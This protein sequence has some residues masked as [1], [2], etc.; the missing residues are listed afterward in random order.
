[1]IEEPDR[2]PLFRIRVYCNNGLLTYSVRE[3]Y[4]VAFLID[5]CRTRIAHGYATN[6]IRVMK[7]GVDLATLKQS[8]VIADVDID[9]TTVLSIE[10][11]TGHDS[12]SFDISI[13]A[14]DDEMFTIPD[15][16]ANW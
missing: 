15:A 13:G 4:T 12:S 6:S 11:R 7:D 5:I 3:D 1:M 14:L 2:Y 8:T 16:N 10:A 9:E